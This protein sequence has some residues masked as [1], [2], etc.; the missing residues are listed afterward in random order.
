M[1]TTIWTKLAVSCL[2]IMIAFTGVATPASAKSKGYVFKY[3]SV[4]VTMHGAAK[5][6]IK[7]AGKPKKKVVKKSCAYKGKDRTYTYKDFKLITY[8]KSNNGPEYVNEIRF[9]T[10]KVATKEGIRIG[11]SVSTMTKKYG[12]MKPKFGIYTY[13]KGSC[14][15]QFE[16][17]GNKV[18]SIRYLAA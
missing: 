2:A 5:N 8:S 7:T 6:L 12:K 15:L 13:K 4:S 18:S 17:N 10:K 1:K 3:K 11:S 16:V 14:K 9:L